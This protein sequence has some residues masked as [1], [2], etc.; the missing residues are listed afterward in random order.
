VIYNIVFDNVN[1]RFVYRNEEN[2]SVFNQ[3]SNI[4]PLQC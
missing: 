3:P 2:L 4:C 1:I